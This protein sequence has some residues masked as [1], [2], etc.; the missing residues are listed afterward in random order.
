MQGVFLFI[1]PDHFKNEQDHTS[2]KHTVT[3][4]FDITQKDSYCYQCQCDKCGR[5]NSFFTVS[6]Y[7]ADRIYQGK[8]PDQNR[9][10]YKGRFHFSV[11]ILVL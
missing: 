10:K 11:L 2:T 5:S 3:D 4:H 1:F 7:I 9:H 8:N 6:F